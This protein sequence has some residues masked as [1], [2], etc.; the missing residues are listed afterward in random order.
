MALLV[1]D[2]W[3]MI[4]KTIALTEL[5]VHSERSAD[6]RAWTSPLV[7]LSNWK[8]EKTPPDV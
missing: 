5:Y 1:L 6:A 2:L 7:Y 4:L 3:L 8:M